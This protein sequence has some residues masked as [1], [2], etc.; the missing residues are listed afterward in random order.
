MKYIYF[1]LFLF[2]LLPTSAQL[3]LTD[4]TDGGNTPITDG[5]VFNIDKLGISPSSDQGK[6]KFRISNTSTTETIRVLGEMMSFTNTDGSQCQYCIQPFC[7]FS[8]FVGQTIPNNP[9][10]LAPGADN[11]DFDSF[12]N[13]DPGDGM[14]YPISYTF[15]FY[16]VDDNDQEV[17]DDIV[18]TFNYT[19]E[20]FSTVGFAPQD[21]GVE[22]DSTIVSEY[23]DFNFDTKV[24]FSLID[25]SGK[26]IED[27]HY[28]SGAYQHNVS[29]LSSGQYILIFKD[30]K[31]RQAQARFYKK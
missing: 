13:A 12:Y 1:I 5:Y 15:R 20:S 7:F 25:L 21:L 16:M 11:G 18:I 9:I 24:S 6:L 3:A 27:I 10:Q 23:L 26:I 19:P 4:I 17:G 29:K 28:I 22:L 8:T 31:G 30:E 14:N 2:F